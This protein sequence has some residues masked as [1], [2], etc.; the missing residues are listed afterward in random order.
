MQIRT[1]IKFNLSAIILALLG[2]WCVNLV[3][4]ASAASAFREL[5][6][7]Q[8]IDHTALA[9]S[10]PEWG[11]SPRQDFADWTTSYVR[12]A[13][14]GIPCMIVFLLN[15]ILLWRIETGSMDTDKQVSIKAPMK[16][17]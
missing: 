17:G 6:S 10:F 15:A 5:E 7:R 4:W 16:T 8:V 12:I 3:L 11:A 13:L 14:L 1:L 9:R 2:M